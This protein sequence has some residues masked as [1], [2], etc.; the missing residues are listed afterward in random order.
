MSS[1]LSYRLDSQ[2]G[3]VTG[4]ANGIGRELAIGLA[5]AGADI[6]IADLPVQRANAEDTARNV[7]RLGRQALTLD[8]DVTSLHSIEAVVE[9]T[10]REF[11]KLDF[12]VNNAGTNIRKPVL[13]YSEAEWEAIVSVNLKGAFFCSQAAGRQMREQKR[14]KI[15]NI[16][17]QLAAVAMEGRSI[18]AISKAGVAHMTKAFALEL[19]PHGITVNSVGPT[20]V[21]TPMTTS[22][23]TDP[24]F[25]AENLPKI[26]AGRFGTPADVLGAVRFLLSP[27][28][29]LVN[30]HLLLVD[31]GYT[32]L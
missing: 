4:S 6:V 1:D 22:M 5:E 27:A 15:V 3:I 25:V 8:L 17:S 32:V 2:V 20:F 29:D 21:S 31:G 16:A 13:E 24:A 11:G 12:L 28:A 26:P 14:G 7:Q 9:T 18:Y 30:G 19:A 10:V 23:F